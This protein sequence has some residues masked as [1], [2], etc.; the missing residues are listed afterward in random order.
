MRITVDT[1]T[2]GRNEAEHAIAI[3]GAFYE[4]GDSKIHLTGTP[5]AALAANVAANVLPVTSGGASTPVVINIERNPADVFGAPGNVPPVAPLAAAATPPLNV[6]GVPPVSLAPAPGIAPPAAPPAPPVAP[7]ASAPPAPP[8]APVPA[9][10][11][12]Y[13]ADGLPWDPRIHQASKGKTAKGVWKQRKGLNDDAMVARVKAELLAAKAVGVAAAPVAATVPTPPAPP[14]VAPVPFV[15][16]V[17]PS[18]PAQPAAPLAPAAPTTVLEFMPRITAAMAS[19]LLPNE[20]LNWACGQFGLANVMA[21]NTRPEYV[22]AVWEK[23]RG[24]YPDFA[25]ANP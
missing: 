8:P 15:Q 21:L 14:A 7:T 20:A 2:D 18:P 3:I 5:P 23:L 1:A 24:A 16:P 22:P 13:D 11:V 9:S 25:A 10:A 6:P 19:Q 12:E 17:A 4:L